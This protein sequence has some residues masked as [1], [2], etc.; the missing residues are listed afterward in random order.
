[1]IVTPASLTGKRHVETG[2]ARRLRICFVIGTLERGGAEGQLVQLATG[3]NRSRFEPSVCCLT[4]NGPHRHA[5]EAAGIPV[6]ILGLRRSK[7]LGL[8]I[9]LPSR[10][11]RLIRIIRKRQPDIVHGFLFGAYVLGAV[12][13]RVNRVPLIVASRRSLGL[14]KAS[15]PL[16]L[17]IERFVNRGTDHLIANS[18]AVRLDVVRQE[19]LAPSKVTVIY[20]GVEFTSWNEPRSQAL[21]RAIGVADRRPIIA[22][23]ANFIAYKGHEFLF[24]ALPAIA[25]EF[26]QLAVLL[27][28]DGPLRQ[29]FEVQVRANGLDAFA[30]F[31]GA[32]SDVPAILALVDLVVHP[33]TQEGFSNAILEAMAAG[34]PVVAAAVG[35]NE[36]AIVDRKTGLLVR[37]RDA[38]ALATASL[39]L[40][41]HPEEARA[42]GM[43]GRTR[44]QQLFTVE[45][46]VREYESLYEQLVTARASDAR[47]EQWMARTS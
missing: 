13:G 12:A 17:L 1:M 6:E 31:L 18:R 42:M 30:R 2:A 34:K 32:R 10:M 20:N 35:G 36:E 8:P 27:V 19:G 45:R 21:V 4:H 39:W 14:F 22:V 47:S 16:W 7:W 40:L 28:G 5:L 41:R 26:P 25:A 43:A 46:M 3:L 11:L 15:R 24:D 38:A 37:N 23:V 33:S 9:A 44:V 29:Q